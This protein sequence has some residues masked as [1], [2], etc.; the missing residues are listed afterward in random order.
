M[1]FTRSVSHRSHS[2]IDNI[3]LLQLFGAHEL[4]AKLLRSE[5]FVRRVFTTKTSMSAYLDLR[6]S[7]NRYLA[8]VDDS[9]LCRSVGQTFSQELISSRVGFSCS[10]TV[11]ANHRVIVSVAINTRKYCVRSEKI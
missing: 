1:T 10:A 9:S 5:K 11:T 6:S 8:A 3:S 4:V 7:L 2:G